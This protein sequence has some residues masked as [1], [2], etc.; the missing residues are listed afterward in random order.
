MASYLGLE[1]LE[2]ALA[3]LAELLDLLGSL[4]LGLLQPPCLACGITQKSRWSYQFNLA[5]QPSARWPSI[6]Q[7][8]NSHKNY[9]LHLSCSLNGHKQGIQRLIWFISR[10]M[11]DWLVF[12]FFHHIMWPTHNGDGGY[13]ST[14]AGW[15]KNRSYFSPCHFQ[16]DFCFWKWNLRLRAS[17]TFSAAFFSAA[18]NCWIPCVWLAII[19]KLL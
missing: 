3:L 2:G 6:T 19:S 9:L 7:S 5:N 10:V 13:G 11:E 14:G 1:L 18:S 12:T 15:W 8:A 16:L 17:A 4:V